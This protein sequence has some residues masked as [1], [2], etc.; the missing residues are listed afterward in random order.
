MSRRVTGPGIELGGEVGG[1]GGV[2]GG[3]ATPRAHRPGST[4]PMAGWGTGGGATPASVP[5][6]QSGSPLE[7]DRPLQD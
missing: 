6:P 2:R 3:D 1:G 7:L 4:G 5:W